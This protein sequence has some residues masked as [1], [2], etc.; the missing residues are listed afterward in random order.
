MFQGPRGPLGSPGPTGKP[1]RR[2]SVAQTELRTEERATYYIVILGQS[3]SY[4]FQSAELKDG[5]ILVS[6]AYLQGSCSS[7]S[8]HV[9]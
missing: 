6:V 1:G 2:V 5:H 9:M 7:V 8:G 3:S 4:T